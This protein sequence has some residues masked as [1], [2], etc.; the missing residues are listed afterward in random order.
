MSHGKSGR[1]DL[2]VDPH[3]KQELYKILGEDG[4]TLK[5]WFLGQARSYLRNRNQSEMF[6]AVAEPQARF[7][8]K[9]KERE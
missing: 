5:E 2:E 6:V 4:M 7:G 1:I 8:G 9:E 3:K